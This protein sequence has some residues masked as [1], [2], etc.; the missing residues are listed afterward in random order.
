MHKMKQEA[1][2]A[3]KSRVP[4]STWD[5]ELKERSPTY[6]FWDM[7]MR[8]ETLI[9]IFVRSH[10]EKDFA[11]YVAVLEKLVPLFF[12]LDH[13]NYSRWV[14]IRVRDMKSLPD[15]IKHEFLVQH[16]WVLSKTGNKFSSIPLDQ[17]H[18]QENK[19]VKGAGGAVGL[20]ENPTA[21]RLV[22]MTCQ[23]SYSFNLY[24][25]IISI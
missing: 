12:A 6:F 2:L 4:F 5:A 14:P 10:R 1:H 21:F 8:F 18:E 24:S 20:T 11:L 23:I 22:I 19:Q 15:T 3:S 17:V 7:I 13:V 25:N 9:L 16:H